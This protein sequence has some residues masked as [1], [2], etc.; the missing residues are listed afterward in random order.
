MKFPRSPWIRLALFA[1]LGLAVIF[2]LQVNWDRS[3]RTAAGVPRSFAPFGDEIR[4]AD[5]TVDYRATLNKLL[6]QPPPAEQNALAIY[7]P[8]ACQRELGG[9][10]LRPTMLRALGVSEAS[11]AASK[12]FYSDWESSGAVSTPESPALNAIWKGDAEFPLIAAW[13]DRYQPELARIREATR[14]RWYCPLLNDDSNALLLGDLLPHIQGM[15]TLARMLTADCYREAGRGNIDAALSDVVSIHQLGLQVRG[16]LVIQNLVA[17]AIRGLARETALRLLREFQLSEQQ[18]KSISPLVESEGLPELFD[19]RASRSERYLVLDLLQQIDRNRLN[20]SELT[21]LARDPFMAAWAPRVWTFL[22]GGQ[23]LSVVNRH[24]DQSGQVTAILQQQG[25]AIAK[26]LQKDAE[27]GKMA[28]SE[29]PSWSQMV[30]MTFSPNAR[31]QFLGEFLRDSLTIGNGFDSASVRAL[32]RSTQE[33]RFLKLVV[34]VERF[35]CQNGVYPETLE[36]LVPKQIASLPPDLFA[37]TGSFGYE[38]LA[39]GFRLFAGSV[40]P[41]FLKPENEFGLSLSVARPPAS[42]SSDKASR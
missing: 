6:G 1:C 41:P 16:D 18:L 17:I 19:P 11:F 32:I 34:E 23:A 7:L 8:L 4:R 3:Y 38:K 10:S 21:G 5:G 15:R 25:N 27:P 37:E 22:D 42:R 2:A 29:Q 36:E 31:G 20:A 39:S 14:L 24:F 33:N 9:S 28:G 30:A 35:R 26:A 12:N 40:Y 13:L